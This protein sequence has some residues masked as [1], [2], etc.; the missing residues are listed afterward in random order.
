MIYFHNPGKLELDLVRIM[1]AHVKVNDNPIGHFGTGLKYA[2][3]TLL[4]TG[5]TIRLR[6]GKESYDFTTRKKE[7]R[8]KEFELVYMNDEQLPFTLD[9]GKNWEVWQAYRE[10]HSN[11][12]DEMGDIS[13]QPPRSDPD[14]IFMVSGSPITKAFYDRDSIF[15]RKGKPDWVIPGYEVWNEPSKYLYYRGVRVYEPSRPTNLTYNRISDIKLTEDRTLAMLSTYY[16][17]IVQAVC[18]ST[19]VDLISAV[20][21]PKRGQNSA[22]WEFEWGYFYGEPSP[23]FLETVRDLMTRATVS[24]SALKLYR[25]HRK[26]KEDDVPV[27]ETSESEDQ[28]IDEALELL[29]I[30]GHRMKRD[31]FKI[32]ES[33]G[34]GVLGR[35]TGGEILIAKETLNAGTG[36]LAGTLYEEYTHLRLG[37]ADESRELQNYL[38]NQIVGLAEEVRELRRRK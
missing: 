20:V 4:R 6:V 5:H 15:L 13:D 32:V 18:T 25:K 11:T 24:E 19:Y 36:L 35:V 23:A 16:S 14:T 1:G 21:A 29:R 12:L 26:S 34:V 37:M 7:I 22:E 8:G 3:S 27:V 30:M 38:V 17:G 10:L 2:I 33:L 28:R 9:L 31:E